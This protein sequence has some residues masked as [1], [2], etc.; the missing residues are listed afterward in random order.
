MF[1]MI[2]RI[3]NI[4]GSYRPRVMAAF[5][6]SFLKAMTGK[7]PL[8]LAFAI[9]GKFLSSSITS[10]D[11]LAAGGLMVLFLV[12]QALFQYGSDRLQSAAGY[13]V[14]ADM[15]MRLGAHLR[16]LPMG[17]FTEGNIGKISSVLSTDMV[18]IEEKCMAALA[19]LMSDLFAQ[20]VLVL[21]M[22]W[23]DPLLG[24]ASA[25]VVLT[26]W[27]LGFRLEKVNR[28]HSA[29][30]QEQSEQL[31]GAVLDFIEGIGV[32][33]S[34]N[35]LGEKSAEL[36]ENF[37]RSCDSSIEYEEALAPGSR[38]LL[39]LTGGGSAVVLG[40]ADRKSTRLNPVTIRS[41]MPSS[42]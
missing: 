10:R 21:F 4:T 28:A 25:L 35:L 24:L 36:T 40:L 29:A 16:R 19:D 6:F 17:Y 32:I 27:L 1:K 18:F 39:F 5:V 12:L 8:M 41:R 23:F 37:R 22:L 31:T 9:L 34:Y 11:C 20:L 42:A 3:L 2:S 38:L 30:R 7:M 33:K 13:L 26:V 15:R 14:F